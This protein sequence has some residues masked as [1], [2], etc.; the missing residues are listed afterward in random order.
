MA[1]L[2]WLAGKKRLAIERTNERT[3]KTILKASIFTCV[4]QSTSS[5]SLF[6]SRENI[7][8]ACIFCF[9][10]WIQSLTPMQK[11][12]IIIPYA[13]PYN[14]LC[15]FEV[16]LLRKVIL[17][18]LVSRWLNIRF[19]L[20]F[21]IL[22][23]L[24]VLSHLAIPNAFHLSFLSSL[25]SLLLGTVPSPP[26]LQHLHFSTLPLPAP[27]WMG[28]YSASVFPPQFHQRII[29]LMD[30]CEFAMNLSQGENGRQDS[31]IWPESL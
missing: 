27:L 4:I 9:W 19:Q 2:L 12:N 8:C 24:H 1:S 14:R 7:W 26:L 29:T 5:R 21:F 3:K 25:F 18:T 15:M 10:A 23:P 20:S 28:M 31:T 16:Q 30:V 6:D 17:F 13:L 11:K 22:Y